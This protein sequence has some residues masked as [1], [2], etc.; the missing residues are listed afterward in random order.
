MEVV[1]ERKKH[2]A[3]GETEGREGDEGEGK[4]DGILSFYCSVSVYVNYTEPLALVPIGESV[5]EGLQTGLP[6]N[7]STTPA[8][9]LT[10]HT[11]RKKHTSHLP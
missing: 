6:F 3:A 7:Y 5:W 9:S 2:Q 1:T 8:C 4:T 11:H 10:T